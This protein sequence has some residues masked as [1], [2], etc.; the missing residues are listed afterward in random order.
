MVK[1]DSFLPVKS[2]KEYRMAADENKLKVP[3]EL[4]RGAEK[5]DEH[6]YVK[7]G[8]FLLGQL[9]QLMGLKD[10]NDIRLLDI[11]C[12][13]RFTQAILDYNIPLKEY[14]GVDVY[15]KLIDYLSKNVSD[16]RFSFFHVNIHNELYNPEGVKLS[17]DTRLP[18]KQDYFDI[19]CLYSVFTHSEPHDYHNMLRILRHHIKKDGRILFSLFVNK[20]TETGFGLTDKIVKKS[21]I[22]WDAAAVPDYI[23]ANPQS[24]LWALYSEK[25]A[26]ELIKGTGWEVVDLHEPNQYIQHHFVCRPI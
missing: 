13:T 14:V 16:P 8:K 21:G 6:Q 5:G 2:I 10:L 19:I 26:K 7:K 1:V 18:V 17:P 11:G 4:F 24:L 15:K 25:N 12:G 9:S 22:A 20:I 3:S 23:D